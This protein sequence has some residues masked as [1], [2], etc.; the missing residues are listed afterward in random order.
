MSGKLYGSQPMLDQCMCGL[1][2]KLVF[3][4]ADGILTSAYHMY[5]ML[6]IHISAVQQVNVSFVLLAAGLK[7]KWKTSRTSLWISSISKA[8]K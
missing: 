3:L 1:A 8:K 6:C 2:Q 5:F 7:P 4:K